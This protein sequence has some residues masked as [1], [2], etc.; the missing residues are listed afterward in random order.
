MNKKWNAENYSSGFSFVYKYGGDI[1]NLIEGDMKMI[2]EL[3][4]LSNED[5]TKNPSRQFLTRRGKFSLAL[6]YCFFRC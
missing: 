2:R 6:C 4:E 1:L 5:C 3:R